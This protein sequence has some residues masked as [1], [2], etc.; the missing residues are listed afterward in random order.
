MSN[1]ENTN[2]NREHKDRLFK[3]IFG[4]E[5]NKDWTLALYNAIN[6]SNYTDSDLIEFNT[7]ENVLYMSMKNDVS[8]LISDNMNFFEHQ[9][10]FNPNIPIRIFIYA[11]MV[12]SKYIEVSADFNL[13]SKTIQKLPAPQCI[14]FYNGTDRKKDIIDLKLSDS[15][16]DS[17]KSSIEVTVKMININYGHNKELMDACAPLKEYSWFVETVRSNINVYGNL[18]KSV[19]KA[20]DTMPDSFKIKVFLIENRAEVKMMCIT[21]YDEAKAKEADKR[22]FERELAKVKEEA[23]L[24]IAEAN[25]KADLKVAEANEKA[26]LKIAEANEKANNCENLL[27]NSIRSLMEKSNFKLEEAMDVLNIPLDNRENFR[28]K[29]S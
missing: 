22:E 26:D 18:D 4:N 11:G 10:T 8:F 15:F 29:I 13:Y 19:D 9:S 23:D 3:F 16:T 12:Y 21:E 2:I 25:E 27:I 17:K 14:C 28:K 20:L 5:Q 6:G 1:V 24:K 7:I